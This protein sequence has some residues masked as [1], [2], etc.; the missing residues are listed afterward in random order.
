MVLTGN[1]DSKAGI[2]S[3]PDAERHACLDSAHATL[4]ILFEG[5]TKV[6]VR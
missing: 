6:G 3:A 5:L 2:M 1:G 4:F